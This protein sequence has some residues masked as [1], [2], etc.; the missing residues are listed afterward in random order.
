M[1][2]AN[3]DLMITEVSD[4]TSEDRP[5][6]RWFCI[7]FSAVSDVDVSSAL[8]LGQIIEDLQSRKI[9]LVFMGVSPHVL[10]ELRRYEVIAEIGEDAVFEDTDEVIAA[11]RDSHH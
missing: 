11:Y 4:L 9:K 8:A 6:V 3:N 5:R 1:Y 7:D 2:Y 10:A